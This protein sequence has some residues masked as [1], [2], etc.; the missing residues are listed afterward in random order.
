MLKMP[1][2]NTEAGGYSMY[3]MTSTVNIDVFI[4]YNTRVRRRE[5]KSN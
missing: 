3:I 4:T 1:T 2:R 5:P